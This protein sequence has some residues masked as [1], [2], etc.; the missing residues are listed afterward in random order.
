M[1]PALAGVAL[2]IFVGAIVAA[3]TRDARIA[4]L[5]LAVA[6]VGS[7][8]LA[9]PIASPLGL[10]AR[11][12]AALLAT[13]LLW[14]AVRDGGAPTGGSRLG[15]AAEASVATAAAIVGYGTHGLGVAG[16]GPALA[17]AVG[18][19]LAALAVTPLV[20]GRDTVRIGLGLLLLTHGSLLVRVALGG[21][22]SPLEELVT[23]GFIAGLGGAVAVLSTAARWDGTDGGFA[24]VMPGRA[25][26]SPRPTTRPDRRRIRPAE[27]LP[28]WSGDVFPSDDA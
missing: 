22:P 27:S 20:T 2:A 21:T 9:D 3:S 8:F 26:P 23:A 1:N 10:A 18:F 11:I 4:T 28:L 17:Q 7:P 12:V 13:Y 6:A 24:L 15:W 5:G 16:S 25:E 14:I 19:A